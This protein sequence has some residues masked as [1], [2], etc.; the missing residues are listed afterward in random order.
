MPNLASYVIGGLMAVLATD[1]FH[2]IVGIDPV[3]SGAAGADPA[4]GISTQVVDRLHKGDRLDRPAQPALMVREFQPLEA[5]P[6]RVQVFRRPDPR[7]LPLPVGC[8]AFASPLAGSA[9][10]ELAGRCVT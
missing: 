3:P 7:P 2:P 1:Y 4:A 5:R 6:V 10:S 8:D 9:L